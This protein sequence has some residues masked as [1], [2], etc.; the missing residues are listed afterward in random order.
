MSSRYQGFC[1]ALFDESHPP[2]Y[3]ESAMEYL[4]FGPEKT[5]EGRFHWQWFCYFKNA[6]SIAAAVKYMQTKWSKKANALPTSGDAPENRVYCGA[7]VYDKGDKH[8]DKNPLFEEFGVCPMANGRSRTLAE[9]AKSVLDG[10]L[11]VDEIA[12][13]APKVFHQYGRTLERLEDIGARR[14]HRTE[15]TTCEWIWGPTGTGKSHRAFDG[16]DESTH[17]LFVD[18]GD[19]GWDGYRGQP[20]VIINEFRGGIK[21]GFLLTLLDK[22]PV[23]VRRRGRQPTPFVSKHIIIT[24]SMH[25]SDLYTTLDKEDKLEQLYRRITLVHLEEVF[26]A[27]QVPTL[28]EVLDDLPS[29]SQDTTDWAALIASPRGQAVTARMGPPSFALGAEPVFEFEDPDSVEQF[30]INELMGN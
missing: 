25:P 28:E 26:V 20:T 19:W 9:S 15:C 1:G 11:T 2:I 18:D 16:Y 30:A 27:P 10:S 5:D 21:F 3:E 8:K 4:C 6:K 12:V 14:V 24:S 29:A 22:W 23:S 13:A 17:Y 7:D